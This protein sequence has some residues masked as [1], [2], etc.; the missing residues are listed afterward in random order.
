[1]ARED[2]CISE[3]MACVFA[4]EIRDGEAVCSPGVRSAVP[5]AAWLLA[6]QMQ[7]P[8][9]TVQ[10]SFYINSV[11][12]VGPAYSWYRVKGCEAV[13]RDSSESRDIKF[14]GKC[15]VDMMGGMQVDKYG[16]LNLVC[17]GDWAHPKKRGPGPAGQSVGAWVKRLYIWLNEHSKRTFVEKVD[18]ISCPGYI[19]GPGAREKAGLK[20]GGPVLVVSPIAV[21]DFDPDTKRMRLKSVH[22]GK[23]V[24]EVVSNT[25]F[26]LVIPRHVPETM[27]P[28]D[29]EINILRTKVD[30]NGFL[31]KAFPNG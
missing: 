1:M 23:T 29:E 7:A 31:R 16:N 19:D 24:D 3:L 8:N 2:Y 4:R 17:I 20:W 6:R 5:Q 22:P 12:P 10:S 13:Y 28:S 30:P 21:M 26:E 9:A 27:P 14:K 11:A 25:G 15:D 18:F